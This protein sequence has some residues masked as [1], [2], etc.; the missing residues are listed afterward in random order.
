MLAVLVLYMILPVQSSCGMGVLFK[1]CAL[2]SGC[3]RYV[4][5]GSCVHILLAQVPASEMLQATALELACSDKQWA[6]SVPVESLL[7]VAV[8]FSVVDEQQVSNFRISYSVPAQ[9]AGRVSCTDKL[10]Q[11]AV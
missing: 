5:H 2:S 1:P 10:S 11:Y 4:L 7:D 6:V 8:G 9:P 3:M